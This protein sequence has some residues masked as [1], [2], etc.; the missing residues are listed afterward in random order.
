[1]AASATAQTSVDV[2]LLSHQQLYSSYSAGW[3]YTDPGGRELALVGASTG[4]SIVDVT[5]P[6]SP[7]QVAFI[8]GLSSSWREMKT[9]SHY[10][11]IVT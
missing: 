4:T 8:P 2:N 9:Y 10:A 1:M 3:G 7:M 6:T 5:T 11:Y